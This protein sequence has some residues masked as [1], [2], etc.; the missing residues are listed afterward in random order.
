MEHTFR[1]T[2]SDL[3]TRTIYHRSDAVIRH[4]F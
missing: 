2:K 1:K 4:V 3:K